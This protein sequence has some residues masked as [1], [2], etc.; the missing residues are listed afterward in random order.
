MSGYVTADLDE[1]ARRL[2]RGEDTNADVYA[3]NAVLA[4]GYLVLGD[5]K[6]K[7]G[8]GRRAVDCARDYALYLAGHYRA[9]GQRDGSIEVPPVPI[10]LFA[11]GTWD[12]T[13]TVNLDRGSIDFWTK[14]ASAWSELP[15]WARGQK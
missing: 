4:S 11:D 2:E 14:V 8:Q 6:V 13:S 10:V 12:R 3:A 1:A 15:S 7:L 5:G 9:L